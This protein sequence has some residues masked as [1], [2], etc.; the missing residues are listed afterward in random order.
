M[1]PSIPEKIILCDYVLG[2][3]VLT[4]FQT[5]LQMEEIL[6]ARAAVVTLDLSFYGILH[7]M[8]SRRAVL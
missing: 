3:C 4:Q 6:Q 1:S 7:L 8:E 5:L 2:I